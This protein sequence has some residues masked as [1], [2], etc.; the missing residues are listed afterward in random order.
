MQHAGQAHVMN[1]HKFARRLGR[2]V[3]ARHRLSDDAVGFGSL[4]RNLVGEF[5]ADDLLA[6]Q[7]AVADAAVMSADQPVL[8]VE[9]FDGQF[10]PLRRPR[11]QELPRLCG[12]LAKRHRRYLDG[13]AGDGR[14]LIGHARGVAEHHNDAGEGYV[15]FFGDDLSERRPDACT[16]V[17]MAVEGHDRTLGR[18][19]DEGFEFGFAATDSRAHNRQGSLSSFLIFCRTRRGHQSRASAASPAARITARTISICA[20]HRQ[21]L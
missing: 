12:G 21:R 1:K 16:Q 19:P 20:P 13:L 15:E 2:Q 5:K 3:R 7:F 11:Q 18:Y 6:D 9:V 10:K 17:D 14:T 4:D 8:H